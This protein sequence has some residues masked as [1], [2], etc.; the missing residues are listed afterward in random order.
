MKHLFDVT[1]DYSAILTVCDVEAN[2]QKEA[3]EII[4]AQIKNDPYDF[5]DVHRNDVWLCDPVVYRD[6]EEG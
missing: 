3:N 6:N 5:L 4:E 2:T 1:I